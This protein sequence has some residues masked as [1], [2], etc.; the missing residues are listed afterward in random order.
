MPVLRCCN[1]RERLGP[2]EGAGSFCITH[3]PGW[4][5]AADVGG[6]VKLNQKH[7][8]LAAGRALKDTTVVVGVRDGCDARERG[9]RAAL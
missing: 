3:Q 4:A 9:W 8:D 1:W 5:K 6:L 7:I 2:R